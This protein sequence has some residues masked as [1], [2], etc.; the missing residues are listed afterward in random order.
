M[1]PTALNALL[2]AILLREGWPT[3]TN[4]AA[5][6]GGPTKGGITLKTL[7]E[8][9]GRPVS[10]A[11]LQGLSD[12][13]ARNLYIDRYVFPWNFLVYDRLVEVVV[14]YAVTSGHD[15]PTIA[16]QEK[17]KVKVDGR[18]GNITREAIN[19][20]P[21]PEGL[22]NHVTAARVRYYTNLALRDRKLQILIADHHD[23]Q[24]LNLRG[25]IARATEFL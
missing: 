17:V 7:Q 24:L 14:D 6:K 25:W 9:R 10:I 21:D 13:E 11:D 12:R 19:N 18:L 8:Y 23:L 22:R 15:Q 1:T 16:L 3:Y 20:Y 2:D 5:D 4:R